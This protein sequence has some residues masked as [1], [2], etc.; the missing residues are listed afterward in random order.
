MADVGVTVVVEAMATVSVG[1]GRIYRPSMNFV[2]MRALPKGRR[3]RRR[4]V[5]SRFRERLLIIVS[6][7]FPRSDPLAAY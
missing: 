4:S 1:C 6:V 7:P 5:K 2:S 3:R